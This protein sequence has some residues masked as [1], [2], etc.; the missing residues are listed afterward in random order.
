[1]PIEI[2]DIETAPPTSSEFTLTLHLTVG[3]GGGGD[4]AVPPTGAS[5]RDSSSGPRPAS[6]PFTGAVLLCWNPQ[7]FESPEAPPDWTPFKVRRGSPLVGMRKEYSFEI[8]L[9]IPEQHAFPRMRQL[10]HGR[11][12]RILALA[13]TKNEIL[14]ARVFRRTCTETCQGSDRKKKKKKK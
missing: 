11:S 13:L 5:F 7:H 14:R 6:S 3:S 4:P 12:R 2:D 1:M 8:K 9:P 10:E